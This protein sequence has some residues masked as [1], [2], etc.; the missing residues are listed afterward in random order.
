MLFLG[1]STDSESGLLYLRP[2]PCLHWWFSRDG[3]F[4]CISQ[5]TFSFWHLCGCHTCQGSAFDIKWTEGYGLE[6]LLNSHC[7][8]DT[9]RA[10]PLPHANSA[11]YERA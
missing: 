11:K 6:V 5:G 3:K 4:G 1:L 9:S 2:S 7:T 8:Q 10:L